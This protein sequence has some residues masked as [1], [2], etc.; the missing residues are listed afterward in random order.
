VYEDFQ[1]VFARRV[2]ER[3]RRDVYPQLLKLTKDL[4]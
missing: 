1:S 4:A 3:K 2:M